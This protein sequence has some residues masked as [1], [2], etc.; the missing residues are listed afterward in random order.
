[1]DAQAPTPELLVRA[2]R[3]G[4]FPMVNSET[5]RIEYFSPDPRTILS[6]DDFHVP[7]SLARRVRSD[8]FEIRT[9]THFEQ[10]MRECAESRPD[11]RDTWIDERLVVAYCGLHELGFA[12]SVEAW[13]EDVLVGGL[14]GV[15][16]GA[17]FFGESMFSRQELGGRDASK[18]CLVWLVEHMREA[19]FELLDTQ[20]MT[21]HL[22][23]FG[24]VEVPRELYLSLL[25]RALA[26][27]AA[28]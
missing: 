22:E 17:A 3:Q 19:G 6:L 10:V 18:V 7:K 23:R 24:A 27:Q 26:S 25:E 4:V 1:M 9:D 5:G 20:F 16:L 13:L 12:H 8:R 2:Y 21:P 14:Y 28:W 11:R 15:H